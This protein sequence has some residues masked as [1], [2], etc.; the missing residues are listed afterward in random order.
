MLV[1]SGSSSPAQAKET[2]SEEVT[3]QGRLDPL[4]PATVKPDSVHNML[5]HEGLR[6]IAAKL[7]AVLILF[8]GAVEEFKAK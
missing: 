2:T 5:Y 1:G 8:W 3:V 7:G 6:M 4:H